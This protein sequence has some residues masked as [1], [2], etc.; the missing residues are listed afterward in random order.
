M[1]T[2]PRVQHLRKPNG[3]IVSFTVV[4]FMT[5]EE[6]RQQRTQV[7]SDPNLLP[8]KAAEALKKAGY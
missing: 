8:Q 6:A 4:P 1:A 3:Q 2:T 7:V 5:L